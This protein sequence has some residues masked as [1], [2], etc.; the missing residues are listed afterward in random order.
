MFFS[1][2]RWFRTVKVLDTFTHECLASEADASLLGRHVVR[3]LEQLVLWYGTPKG[4]TVGYC[5]EF[6][7]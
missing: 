6:S 1:D 2:G 3:L 5:P 4:S 7:G